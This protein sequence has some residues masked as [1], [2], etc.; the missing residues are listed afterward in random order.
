MEINAN[1]VIRNVDHIHTNPSPKDLWN[2]LNVIYRLEDRVSVYHYLRWR[3]RPSQF[4]NINLFVKRDLLLSNLHHPSQK[5]VLLKTSRAMF[6]TIQFI[7]KFLL[8]KLFKVIQILSLDY[9]CNR[10]FFKK[11]IRFLGKSFRL[12]FIPNQSEIFIPILSEVSFQSESIRGPFK[13]NPN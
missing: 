13:I 4:L 1:F 6:P 9:W 5:V 8:D 2:T 12:K 11:F 7:Q 10:Y 3:L